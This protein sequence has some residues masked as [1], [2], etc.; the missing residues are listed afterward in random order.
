MNYPL[1]SILVPC[2]NHEKYVEKLLNSI[3]NDD[4]PNKEIIIINDGSTDNSDNIIKLWLEQNN[5]NLNI[6][7]RYQKNKGICSTLNELIKLSQGQYLIPIASDDLLIPDLIFDRV[8]ILQD[9]PNKL[10]LI[11]DS[12]V[13]DANDNLI[14]E[15][16]ILNYNL[17]DKNYFKTDEAILISTLLK[18][19]ISGPSIL[20]DRSIYL[21]IGYYKENLCAEDWYFY[22]R[23]AAKKLILYQDIYCAFYRVHPKNTSGI[24]SKSELKLIKTIILTYWYNVNFMPTLKFK[25]IAIIELLKWICRYCKLK[26]VFK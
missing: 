22:Q 4:Y 18:P 26:M 11:T 10:V 17:G 25:I 6:V 23:A 7:Y 8:K 21:K 20:I 14:M 3:I 5:T 19:Q 2:Y 16:C 9:N 13:I 1:V 12:K 24:H 15:S